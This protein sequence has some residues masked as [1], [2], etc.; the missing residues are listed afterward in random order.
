MPMWN[1]H[2]PKGTYSARERQEFAAQVTALYAESLGLPRFYVS[3]TFHECSPDEFFI[4]GEPNDRYVSISIDHVARQ[5]PDPER[6]RWWMEQIHKKLARFLGDR[7]LHWEIHIDDTPFEFWAID[8]Y[9]PPAA[10]S[11]DE[12]RWAAENEPSPLIATKPLR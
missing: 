8:G 4:G 2:H 1:V 9:S 11:A 10:G 3:V 7:G 12:R 6:R 5:T